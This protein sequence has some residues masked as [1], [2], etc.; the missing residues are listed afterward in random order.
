MEKITYPIR[1]NKYL[2]QKGH[3]TR[4]GADEM[5]EKGFV[6]IKKANKKK[7]RYFAY[8]KAVGIVS[9]APQKGETDILHETRFPTLVFPIGR[10]D[11]DS[12]GL[13]IMTNDGRITDRLLN[14]AREHD[15]E[16][17]VTVEKP[18]TPDFEKKMAKGVKISSAGEKYLTKPAQVKILSTK[19]FSIILTEGKKRQIRRMCETLKNP[20]KTLTRI[21]I[22]NIEMGKLKQGEFREIAGK[23]LEQ[24]FKLLGL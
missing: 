7:L 18:I 10:L 6:T 17:I 20:V 11:K 5:I 8:N 22:M 13:I 15:K 24:F 16:Y 19:K 3:A 2:A 4:T 12:D 23:E 1:I 21:R 9:S 14:P